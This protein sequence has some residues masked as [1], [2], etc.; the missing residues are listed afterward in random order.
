MLSKIWWT[1]TMTLLVIPAQATV[2]TGS[3]SFNAGLYTYSYQLSASPTPVTE[4]SVLIDSTN[5]NWNLTPVST[6]N[7][8]GWN[9]FT[10]GGLFPDGQ[11]DHYVTYWTWQL[12]PTPSNS[13][14]DAVSGFSFTTPQAPATTQ[15]FSYSYFLYSPYSDL[16]NQGSFYNGN[17]VGP[18]FLGVS[19]PAPIPEPATPMLFAVSGIM[20]W[21]IMSRQK[22]LNVR[23]VK[24]GL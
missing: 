5:A 2:L 4:V 17:V 24:A 13:A 12:W 11:Y 8:N 16:P 1:I 20:L 18:D 3:V 10:T 14:T 21:Q 6:T 22:N 9:F 15:A 19:P 7:P 23:T